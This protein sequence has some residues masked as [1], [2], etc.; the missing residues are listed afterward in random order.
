[1]P[2]IPDVANRFHLSPA[3]AG[4]FCSIWFFA[5]TLT[6]FALSLWSGWHYRF[7]Y[8]ALAYLGMIGAF[9]GTLLFNNLLLVIAVQILL[10]WCVGLIYYS[11]L[12][13]SMHVGQTKGEHGG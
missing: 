1:I 10:G 4:F 7:R 9:A 11:S 8:M 2:L 3:F 13:Y 5:R 6:F 12:Y